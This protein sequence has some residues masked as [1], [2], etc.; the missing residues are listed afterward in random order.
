MRYSLTTTKRFDKAVKRCISRGY[1]IT[2][3]QTA[4]HLLEDTGTLPASYLPH[5]LS[6]FKGNRTWE[7]HLEGD[8][9]LIWEQYDEELLLVMLSTGTHSDSFGKN[10][11]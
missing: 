11:K 3:L 10:R 2:K 1:D 4:M 8:W 7:C 9:I 6:G 5:K